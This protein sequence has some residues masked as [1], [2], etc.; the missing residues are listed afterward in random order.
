VNTKTAICSGNCGQ[1]ADGSKISSR[2]SALEGGVELT[3]SRFIVCQVCSDTD[4]EMGL[5]V[6]LFVANFQRISNMV[7]CKRLLGE[8]SGWSLNWLP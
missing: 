7:T 2:D 5:S 4:H 3:L 1:G 6:M 8:L